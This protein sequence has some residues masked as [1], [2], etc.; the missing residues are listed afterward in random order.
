MDA[1]PDSNKLLT[2]TVIAPDDNIPPELLPPYIGGPRPILDSTYVKNDYVIAVTRKSDTISPFYSSESST[3]LNRWDYKAFWADCYLVCEQAF[4][5]G[6][7]KDHV[8]LLYNM[9]EDFSKRFQGYRYRPEKLSRYGVLDSLTRYNGSFESLERLMGWLANGNS[10]EGIRAMDSTDF[11]LFYATYHGDTVTGPYSY[12]ML[13]KDDSDRVNEARVY[14]TTMARWLNNIHTW[15]QVAIFSSCY[16]GGFANQLKKQSRIVYTSSDVGHESYAIRIGEAYHDTVYDVDL[17]FA[18]GDF[19]YPFFNAI[20]RNE[21]WKYPPFGYPA[22]VDANLDSIYGISFYEAWKYQ[23]HNNS[24][25]TDSHPQ[26]AD[27]GY[28]SPKTYFLAGML[29]PPDRVRNLRMNYEEG[30][31]SDTFVDYSDELDN[32]LYWHSL[33]LFWDPDTTEDIYYYRI[34]KNGTFL[35]WTYG[36]YYYTEDVSEGDYFYVKAVDIYNNVGLPSDTVYVTSTG[37]G[38]QAAAYVLKDIDIQLSSLINGKASIKLILP[39]NKNIEIVLYNSAGR[40]IKTLYKG[41][42]AK[43]IHTLTLDTDKLSKGAYFVVLRTNNKNIT[44]KI[45]VE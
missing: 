34:Y 22:P 30:Y 32:T 9:G 28:I 29:L 8:I 15:R 20:R 17:E 7:D 18:H 25:Y 6:F 4:K 14:D 19:D 36:T 33:E 39:E 16:S 35:T 5:R 24:K 10:S 41:E 40:R 1:L 37:D 11:L 3:N 12:F 44:R 13:N 21:V 26:C 31:V 23:V 43:G 42:T 38:E 2:D 45:V 27:I